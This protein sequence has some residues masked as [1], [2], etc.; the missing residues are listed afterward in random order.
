HRGVP[1]VRAHRRSLR[2][3][4]VT[5]GAI[6]GVHRMPS[7]GVAWEFKRS[8][9]AADYLFA[10]LHFSREQTFRGGT[11]GD[12]VMLHQLQTAGRIDVAHGNL[13]RSD[14]REQ[15]GGPVGPR[16]Q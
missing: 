4:A 10:V 9:I 15:L 11:D 14:G 1:N 12:V 13:L 2:A 8:L 16:G 7:L 5:A 3:D 6:C